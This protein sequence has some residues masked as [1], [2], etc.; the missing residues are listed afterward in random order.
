MAKW[1]E[2]IVAA[3]VTTS[4]AGL[5][6]VSYVDSLRAATASLKPSKETPDR[7]RLLPF[8]TETVV[9]IPQPQDVRPV[10][11]ARVRFNDSSPEEE[12]RE[13]PLTDPN[14][15]RT[16]A[17]IPTFRPEPAAT[18]GPEVTRTPPP[19]L[20]ESLRRIS[21]PSIKLDS[22]IVP[23]LIVNNE[24]Q[25]PCF[26]AGHLE[27]TA[28]PGEIGN[29]AVIGHNNSLACGDVFGRIDRLKPGDM[30]NLDTDRFYLRYRVS[31]IQVVP[32]E[33]LDVISPTVVQ[34]LTL[35]TCTGTFLPLERDFDRRIIVTAQRE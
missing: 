29:I 2:I 13:S 28:N 5:G 7:S 15:V 8:P 19:R 3:C 32:K 16:P 34:T 35:I 1:P 12:L 10:S 31:G 21:A 24:W 9:L 23:S 14:M 6:Y 11:L 20:V 25:V 17:A 30:V 26:V 33:R 22:P 4:V 18:A 27:G